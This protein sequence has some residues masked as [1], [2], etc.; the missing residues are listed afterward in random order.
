MRAYRLVNDHGEIFRMSPTRYRQYLLAGTREDKFPSADKF[1]V[2]I[3][4]AITVNN[5]TQAEFTE[6][7]RRNNLL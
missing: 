3:G 6:E 5:F 1:G 4:S 7:L 2:C